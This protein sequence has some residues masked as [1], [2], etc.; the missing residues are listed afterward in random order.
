MIGGA[1]IR[2]ANWYTPQFDVS[3]ATVA[4]VYVR[5]ALRILG[6]ADEWSPSTN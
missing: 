4:D 3:A 2:V 6:V 1:G 5:Y